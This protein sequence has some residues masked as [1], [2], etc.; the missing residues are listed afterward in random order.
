MAIHERAIDRDLPDNRY[1]PYT[2]PG[3]ASLGRVATLCSQDQGA[4][5]WAGLWVCEPGEYTT[6]FEAN[7][8]F[9]LIEG[10]ADVAIGDER[11]ML[12]PGRGCHFRR[13]ETAVWSVG[14]MLKA[15]VVACDACEK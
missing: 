3:G 12:E 13:G 1:D 2:S 14:E 10:R 5:I 11:L 4:G 8:V 6:P 15:F 9:Y 7:E